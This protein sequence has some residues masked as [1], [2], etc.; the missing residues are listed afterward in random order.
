M[1]NSAKSIRVKPR[2]AGQPARAP[3]ETPIELKDHTSVVEEMG[4]GQLSSFRCICHLLSNPKRYCLHVWSC[5]VTYYVCKRAKRYMSTYLQKQHGSCPCPHRRSAP[6]VIPGSP[7]HQTAVDIVG[8][9]QSNRRARNS[10]ETTSFQRS[11]MAETWKGKLNDKIAIS[12]CI[13]LESQSSTSRASE[14]DCLEGLA[15]A[16]G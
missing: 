13:G 10:I 3:G 16:A 8:G 7:G 11:H 4:D 12:T 1:K 14:R 5:L 2:P 6:T 9:K 15:R